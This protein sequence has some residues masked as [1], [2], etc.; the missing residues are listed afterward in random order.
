MEY[1]KP[2]SYHGTWSFNISRCDYVNIVGSKNSKC[3]TK[4]CLKGKHVN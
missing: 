3:V 2:Q 1:S 4:R